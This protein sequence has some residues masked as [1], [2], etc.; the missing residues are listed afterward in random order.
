MSIHKKIKR[1]RLL[2]DKA[3]TL[4]CQIDKIAGEW[5]R[6][7]DEIKD[8]PEWSDDCDTRGL[9]KNPNFRDNLC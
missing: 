8:T 4:T 7:L 6:L 2:E 9:V 1:I 3:M 5:E